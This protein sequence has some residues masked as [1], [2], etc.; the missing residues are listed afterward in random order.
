MPG[1]AG[2]RGRVQGFSRAARLNMGRAIH[3][4]DRSKVLCTFF[5]TLTVPAGECGWLEI[6][7]H[8]DNWLKRFARQWGWRRA[9]MFWKKEEQKNGTPHLHVLIFW[10]SDPPRL[11][12]FREWNDN[13]WADTVKSPNPHHRRIG[14]QVQLMVKW[15]GVASYISK[16]MTKPQDGL[17][18]DT[19][20]IWGI[21]NR[22]LLKSCVQV[23]VEHVPAPAGKKLRRVLLKLQQRRREKWDVFLDGQWRMVRTGR[24]RLPV[25]D[26][27]R[28]AK[29]AGVRVRRRRARC[30]VTR[31]QQVWA[32]TIVTSAAMRCEVR[33]LEPFGIEHHSYASALHF[34]SASTADVLVRWAVGEYVDDLESAAD[35]ARC[36]ELPF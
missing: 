33:K 25:A 22:K 31:G 3:Q 36:A 17:A 18:C 34:V 26:Q 15:T 14:C 13:A 27:V 20:R 10:V 19:G 5:G 21:W 32:E 23:D 7:K 2:T 16:Y 1:R 35:A 30:M 4:V 12:E 28:H 29:A 9:C 6:E 24:G 11:V 8:R